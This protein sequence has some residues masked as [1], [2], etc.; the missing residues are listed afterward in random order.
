MDFM[1]SL[2]CAYQEVWIGVPEVTLVCV[3]VCVCVRVCVCVFVCACA[4][5]CSL[6]LNFRS[7]AD[8]GATLAHQENSRPHCW[9]CTLSASSSL[10]TAP[11]RPHTRVKRSSKTMQWAHTAV[12]Q[13]VTMG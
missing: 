8:M 4:Y 7:P 3:C 6:P 9:H 11:P 5:V 13:H 2:Q 10:S 12:G 1:D